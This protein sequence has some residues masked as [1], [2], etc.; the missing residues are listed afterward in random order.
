MNP[1]DSAELNVQT[2]IDLFYRDTAEIGQVIELDRDQVPMPA[3][4]LLVHEHH[5]TVTV[6]E[7]FGSAVDVQVLDSRLDDKHYSRKILLTRQSDNCVVQ[8]GIVRLDLSVLHPEVQAEIQSQQTPLGRILINHGV[9]RRVKLIGLC[10][11]DTGEELARY[12]NI[13]PGERVFGRT[14]LIYCD[15]NPAI[16]LLEVVQG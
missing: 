5:M 13:E 7:Y 9:L 15:G 12:F 8:Y 1:A 4:D 11:I 14:A 3:R 2:L 16:E 10:Q 6:E